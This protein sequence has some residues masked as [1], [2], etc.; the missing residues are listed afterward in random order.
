P[1]E[2]LEVAIGGGNGMEEVAEAHSAVGLGV[3]AVLGD[4]EADVEARIGA[5]HD[6]GA[7]RHRDL[8]V[9]HAL[10]RARARATTRHARVGVVTDDAGGPVLGAADASP[11]HGD[12]GDRDVAGTANVP[13][14]EARGVAYALPR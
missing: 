4:P 9:D 13:L 12:R 10:P 8:L 3:T 11:H 6:L 7:H 2:Q 1:V 14:S 5:R